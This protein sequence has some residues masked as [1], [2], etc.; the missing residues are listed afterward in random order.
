MRAAR[1]GTAD[2]RSDLRPDRDVALNVLRHDIAAAHAMRKKRHINWPATSPA[3]MAGATTMPRSPA[4]GRATRHFSIE[5]TQE[6]R[7]T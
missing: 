6:R 1:Q 3:S 7:S 5:V 2:G 4:G